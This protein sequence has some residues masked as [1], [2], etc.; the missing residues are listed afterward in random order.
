MQ[1]SQE[2]FSH[3]TVPEGSF[4]R[5]QNPANDPYSESNELSLNHTILF[6][7]SPF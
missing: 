1:Q 6:L 4:P 3:F 2:N 7:Y 5:S